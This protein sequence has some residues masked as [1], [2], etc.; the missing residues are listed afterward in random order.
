MVSHISDRRP[1]HNP[2]HADQGPPVT[3][4]A[5][6]NI[7]NRFDRTPRPPH[8]SPGRRHLHALML[9]HDALRLGVLTAAARLDAHQLNRARTACQYFDLPD[10]ADLLGRAPQMARSQATAAVFDNVY[11]TRFADG[12]VLSAAVARKAASTPADFPE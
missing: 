5:P 12:A 4:H 6:V 10:L 7:G 2:E 3:P 8:L 11:R 9:V 1:G